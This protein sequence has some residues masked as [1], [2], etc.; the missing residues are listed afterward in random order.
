MR[1]ARG[2]NDHDDRLSGLN[3]EHECVPGGRSLPWS[4]GTKQRAHQNAEIVARNMNEITFVNVFADTQPCA[5]HAAAFENMREA[6]FDDLAA[7]G[8][9]RQKWRAIPYER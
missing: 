5:A 4:A 8:L 2:D 7:F 6:A 9:A 3:D 1:I